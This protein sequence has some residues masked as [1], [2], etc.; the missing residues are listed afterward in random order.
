MLSKDFLWGGAIAA[1][2]AEGAYNCDGKGLS[3]MDVVTGGSKD[4]PRQFTPEILEDAYYPNHEAI[5][6]YHQFET[7]TDLFQQLGFKCFRTS[8][9]WSR[10]F[11]EGDETQPNEAGLAYY[12]NLF[13]TLKAKGMEPVV[14]LS[15]YEMPLALVKKYGGWANRELITFF[16]RYTKV[17]FKRY[18]GLVKY[19]LTFNEINST[20]FIPAI[21]GVIK[22]AY[23]D[24]KQASY[25]ALHHQFVASA[26]AVIT[27]HA[28]DPDNKIG[29][30]VM[31]TVG[32]PKIS[33]PLDVLASQ[34]YLRD[35]T[36]FY[37]DVHLRGAYPNYFKSYG[38]QI[39][40]EPNDADILKAGVCDYLGFSYYSSQVVSYNNE[41]EQA[42]GNIVKG[43][44][45]PYLEA[46]EWGWQ[47]DPEGLSYLMRTLYERY[48]K[49]LFIVE[50]GLGYNDQLNEDKT[51]EDDYRIDYLSR[52]LKV[53]KQM[54]E[55]EEIE[56][57]GYTAWG[58]ID[59]VS[60]GTGEMSKRYGFI[61]VDRD[62]QGN[63]TLKRY[64][65]KSFNWYRQ[66]I[67]SN[68]ECL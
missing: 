24:L 67:E 25:Q 60:A 23:P 33:H 26:Q 9:A 16:D 64:R 17:V 54:I 41:G 53:M 63:G 3:I 18:K 39:K 5:D 65:K 50:N 34:T 37:C 49:P 13:K 7:D 27:G 59:I 48:E 21:A 30:M 40:M 58:P 36:L 32:Y 56:V 28:I 12:E 62:D 45:N 66:V 6:F 31:T 10:I 57:L 8:I 44:K 52:H 4:I 55:T 22:Q 61:Y 47:I 38:V 46:N 43:L 15:H 51:V 14:T 20:I 11:P 19:W 68:G 35:G 1:N 42:D 29:C 2:Q